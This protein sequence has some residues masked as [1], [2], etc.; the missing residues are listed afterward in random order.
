M[1]T[2]WPPRRVPSPFLVPH[3]HALTHLVRQFVRRRHVLVHGTRLK[4][5]DLCVVEAKLHAAS[6]RQ[7]KYLEPAAV[8]E[9]EPNK[10]RTRLR[11]ALEP[12]SCKFSVVLEVQV[13]SC[14]AR[15]VELQ[16]QHTCAIEVPPPQ[17]PLLAMLD[18]FVR[19]LS[20]PLVPDIA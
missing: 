16:P 3:P 10:A 11:C 20:P 13:G 5:A 8:S 6:R 14:K 2:T 7:G 19:S 9:V 4:F 1:T 17:G 15:C 12:L 18:Y